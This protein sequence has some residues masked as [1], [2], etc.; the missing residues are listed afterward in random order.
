MNSNKYWNVNF[1]VCFEAQFSGRTTLRVR[2]LRLHLCGVQCHT[3]AEKSFWSQVRFHDLAINI[4][5][6][7]CLK[8]RRKHYT[9]NVDRTLAHNIWPLMPNNISNL[10]SASDTFNNFI[11]ALLYISNTKNCKTK[12]NPHV[13]NSGHTF[14]I[15]FTI[16]ISQNLSCGI[17]E[18]QT[19][20]NILFAFIITWKHAAWGIC[21]YITMYYF[22]VLF[23]GIYDWST[24]SLTYLPVFHILWSVVNVSSWAV[25][26]EPLKW[27]SIL[28]SYVHGHGDHLSAGSDFA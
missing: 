15:S 27:A 28:G 4:V 25:I 12:P 11:Q 26:R 18:W 23:L 6:I 2:A 1:K 7:V 3:S 17:I 19:S 14:P 5:H 24:H 13:W 22:T 21:T 10:I 16:I 9:F 20:L 8:I